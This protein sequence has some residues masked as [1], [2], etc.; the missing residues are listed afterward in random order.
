LNKNIPVFNGF[1]PD[2]IQLLIDIKNNNNKPWFEANKQRYQESLL[3]PFQALVN[4]LGGFML[5]IDPHFIITPASGKTIS[6]IYRDTRFSK[7][8]S[9]L[10]SSMWL[11]F[12][13]PSPDWK[14][15]P[16]F[17]FEITP[18]HYQYG[19]GFYN[20]PKVFMDGLRERISQNPEPFLQV[21]K[22][23]DKKVFT[24][25]GDQY[26]RIMIPPNLPELLREWYTYKSFY[27][28]C[29]RTVHERLYQKELINDLSVGFN[30]LAPLYQYL[31]EIK[32]AVEAKSVFFY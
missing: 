25:G 17:F 11:T 13:R 23:Y 4:D 14:E 30:S 5:T 7:D 32:Q 18:E 12:K 22:I 16:A 31:W 19:M 3:W 10:R 27:L 29:L 20:A 28:F 24:L 9:L 2:T 26:K 8:K 21:I 15:A 1:T 6:R